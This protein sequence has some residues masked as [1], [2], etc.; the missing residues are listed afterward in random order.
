[1]TVLT[2]YN[3]M[4]PEAPLLVTEDGAV[5]AQELNNVGVRFERWKAQADL[6]ADASQ[7]E[8][9]AAYAPEVERLKREGG[10]LSA[11]VIRMTQDNP[12]KDELRKK[13]LNEHTHSEDEVRFFVE[14]AGAFYLRVDEKIFQVIC[15]K[16]DLI[17]VPTGTRHW[18]DMGP[19]PTF[20]AIRLFESPDGWVANFTGDEIAERFP[21]F[22][23]AA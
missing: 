8:V 5:I 2:I 12:N 19:T 7:D 11:D 6:A 4:T 14:G 9:L 3:E 10:Y 22:E 1:M 20:T 18:F 17:S 16:D 23:S 21:R 13:F 15:T